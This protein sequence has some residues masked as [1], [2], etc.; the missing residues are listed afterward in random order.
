LADYGGSIDENLDMNHVIKNML[1]FTVQ[2][3]QGILPVKK[4]AKFDF[5]SIWELK[6]ITLVPLRHTFFLSDVS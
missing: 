1:D 5:L 4:W 6:H 2:A 3:H